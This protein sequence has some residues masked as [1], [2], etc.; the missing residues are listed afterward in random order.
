MFF[1]LL[2]ETTFLDKNNQNYLCKTYLRL[3]H[4]GSVYLGQRGRHLNT[5]ATLYLCFTIPSLDK[6]K[7]T[8][9]LYVEL[10]FVI[11]IKKNGFRVTVE[12]FWIVVF[13]S[14][15]IYTKVLCLSRPTTV[16]LSYPGTP[17]RA[18]WVGNFR[19]GVS[20]PG[21]LDS[22]QKFNFKPGTRHG[23]SRPQPSYKTKSAKIAKAN[24]RV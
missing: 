18:S 1:V 16:W 2:I 9:G 19:P 11:L 14:V 13:I 3:F 20:K 23:S 15:F 4:R 21:F 5:T 8:V 7:V 12:T 22:E 6:H 24:L 17:G 10:D